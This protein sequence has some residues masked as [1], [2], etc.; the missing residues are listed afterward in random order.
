MIETKITIAET[1]IYIFIIKNYS[2]KNGGDK[3]FFCK[4]LIFY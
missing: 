3:S 2:T 4:M 1:I